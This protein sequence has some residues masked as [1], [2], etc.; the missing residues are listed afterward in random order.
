MIES[1][2]YEAMKSIAAVQKDTK[3]KLAIC[4]GDQKPTG[5]YVGVRTAI[6]PLTWTSQRKYPKA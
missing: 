1:Y 4:L 2:A 6:T 5:Y 3:N